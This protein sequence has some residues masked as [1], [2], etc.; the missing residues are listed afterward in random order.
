MK[1]APHKYVILSAF[2]FVILAI[3]TGA[4]NAQQVWVVDAAGG[5]GSNYTDIPPA[6]AAAVD[7]DTLLVRSGTY[8]P[9]AIL[10]KALVVT[11]DA[12]QAV[13][14][15]GTVTISNLTAAQR[16]CLRG[17]NIAGSFTGAEL[18][19]N[20]GGV[21]L[22]KCNIGGANGASSGAG[23]GSHAV[24]ASQ[25]LNCL[26]T[27]CDFTGGAGAVFPQPSFADGLPGG[28][29][30]L[31]DHCN[32]YLYDCNVKGRRGGDAGLTSGTTTNGG[33]GGGG[34]KITNS[35]MFAS[36]SLFQGGAGGNGHFSGL[37]V[38]L[39]GFGGDGGSGLLLGT[40]AWNNATILN[41]SFVG[42]PAGASS[43]GSQCVQ[44]PPAAGQGTMIQTGTVTTYSGA[45]RSFSLSSPVREQQNSTLQF[46]NGVAGEL[47]IIIFADTFSPVDFPPYL[48]AFIPDLLT[49]DALSIG[50]IGGGGG[51][52]AQ[53]AVPALPPA[54][55]SLTFFVQSVFVDLNTGGVV[56]GPPS[57]ITILDSAF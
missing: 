12:G 48:G 51:L 53:V 42:G 49:V 54:L 2:V 45:S 41:C 36:G 37:F 57:E 33:G 4:A 16:V 22:E 39:C 50:T 32:L 35:T 30:I 21:W 11:A 20:A 38:S 15:Q 6:I 31:A 5:A 1:P 44:F 7:G 8:S 29:G 10:Q 14:V 18:Q 13:S 46:S 23:F 34:A 26:F 9:F 43:G 25:S 19:N 47:A 17:I 28:D 24:F 40:S 3:H 52:T 56:L 27:D 55:Q